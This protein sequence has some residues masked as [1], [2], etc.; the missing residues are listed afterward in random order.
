MM[1][2]C[3]IFTKLQGNVL[4]LDIMLWCKVE[5]ICMI[6]INIMGIFV[7]SEFVWK[8]IGKLQVGVTKMP[9]NN[10][11]R[12]YGHEIGPTYV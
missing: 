11:H 8:C 7:F 1:S 12:R 10:N 2:Q 6:Q 9:K 4:L 3:W 5:V